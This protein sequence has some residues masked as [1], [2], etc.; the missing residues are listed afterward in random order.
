MLLC[1]TIAH[2][3]NKLEEITGSL[4]QSDKLGNCE[5]NKVIK[6]LRPFGGMARL[7]FSFVLLG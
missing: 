2:D 4:H 5:A 7:I 1:F 6:H 3:D